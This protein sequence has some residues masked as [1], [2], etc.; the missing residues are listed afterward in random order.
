MVITPQ[1]ELEFNITSWMRV[2]IGAGY[3][4]VTGIDKAY[5]FKGSPNTIK[6]YDAKDFNSPVGEVSILIGGFSKKAK[7]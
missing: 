5:Q 7:Q 2:N 3:R 6:Y 4:V 1:I